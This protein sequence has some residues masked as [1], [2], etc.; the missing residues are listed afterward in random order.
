MAIDSSQLQ[1]WRNAAKAVLDSGDV[2]QAGEVARA[3]PQ[4]IDE[5]E[6]LSAG[7]ERDRI[8]VHMA[9][10]IVAGAFAAGGDATV[11]PN[12]VAN[13][14][15]EIADALLRHRVPQG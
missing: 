9:Q 7:S 4:V 2:M 10:G 8:A 11:V 1:A 6:R 12:N 14:A 15:Y 3:I 5:L 13:K